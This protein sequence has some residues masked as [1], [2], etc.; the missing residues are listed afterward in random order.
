MKKVHESKILD[1]HIAYFRFLKGNPL[2]SYAQGLEEFKEMTQRPEVNTLMV[3]VEDDEAMFGEAMQQV[4]LDT[5]VLADNNGIEKW[6]VV[7]PNTAKQI[8]IEYLVQGGADGIREY[9]HYVGDDEEDVLDWC[10]A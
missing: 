1:G 3:V 10:K 4:W 6:G 8:T 5:G 9:D 2:E 7:V